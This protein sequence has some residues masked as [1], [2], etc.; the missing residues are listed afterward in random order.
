MIGVLSRPVVKRLGLWDWMR[1]RRRVQ[2]GNEPI[3]RTEG[4]VRQQ[5]RQQ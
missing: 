2:D 5:L 3:R 1:R 4:G